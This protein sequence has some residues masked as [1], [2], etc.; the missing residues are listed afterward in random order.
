ML[1]AVE[2][3]P[4]ARLRVE[5]RQYFIV[6]APRQTGKTTTLAALARELT[7]EGKHVALHDR[8]ELRDGQRTL[9]NTS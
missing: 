2:R 8:V 3:L 6:H 5:R 4:G 7:Q 9:G 1:P